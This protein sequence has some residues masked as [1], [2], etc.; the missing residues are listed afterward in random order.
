MHRK[1]HTEENLNSYPALTTA[2]KP[3]DRIYEEVNNDGILDSNDKVV[4]GN[5]S[6]RFIYSVNLRFGWK[7]LE[8]DIVGTGRSGYSIPMTNAW[9][10]NGWGDGNYSHS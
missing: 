5:T 6:P 3:G 9:F 8:L 4:L 1:I 7:N 10:W 2:I